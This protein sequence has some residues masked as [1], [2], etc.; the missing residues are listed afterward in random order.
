MA[1]WGMASSRTPVARGRRV[2]CARL[3]ADA[4]KIDDR[5]EL[6]PCRRAV[7]LA[8]RLEH[9]WQEFSRNPLPAVGNHELDCVRHATKRHAQRAIFR[10]ELHGVGHPYPRTYGFWRI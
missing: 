3:N 4:T 1:E 7:G 6:W 8:E 10:C 9:G 5:L 2:L